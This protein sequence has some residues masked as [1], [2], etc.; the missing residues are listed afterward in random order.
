[1]A[2]PCH[3]FFCLDENF[4]SRMR[5]QALLAKVIIHVSL[6]RERR[7]LALK[8][9]CQSLKLERDIMYTMCVICV[10]Y[11]AMC[12]VADGRHAAR[13]GVV[14]SCLEVLFYVKTDLCP[15]DLIFLLAVSHCLGRPKK[16][17]D[18]KNNDKTCVCAENE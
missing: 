10:P 13:T 7:E 5:L 9:G 11:N 18:K 17:Q 1:M 3:Y 16:N 15:E 8:S 14:S 6:L 2:K 12:L 4:R